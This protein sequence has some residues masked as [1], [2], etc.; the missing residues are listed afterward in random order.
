MSPSRVVPT[1]GKL[2]EGYLS[3]MAGYSSHKI[4]RRYLAEGGRNGTPMDPEVFD[5]LLEAEK[6]R[7]LGYVLFTTSNIATHARD[8]QFYPSQV[9]R[10]FGLS[11]QGLDMMSSFGYACSRSRFK[12][13]SNKHRLR[14]S[15]K[16][17]SA[18]QNSPIDFDA[19]CVL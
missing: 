16:T 9:A 1:G 17:R 10:F 2:F 5:V 4:W 12:L 6:S 14:A 15:A 13:Q 18:C 7:F 3:L 8:Q 11:Q 19:V